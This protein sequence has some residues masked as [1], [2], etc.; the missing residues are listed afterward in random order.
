LGYINSIIIIIIIITGSQG[1]GSIA[2]LQLLMAR[3]RTARLVT[4]LLLQL[5]LTMT[6]CIYLI[7][8]AVDDASLLVDGCRSQLI[9]GVAQREKLGAHFGQQP[10]SLSLLLAYTR[11]TRC[12]RKHRAVHCGQD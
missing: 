2:I 7:V 5:L 10:L 8:L 12:S 9:F 11:C 6:I 1:L 4:M 3:N